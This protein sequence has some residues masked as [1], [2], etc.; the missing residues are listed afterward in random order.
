MELAR[1]SL[2]DR[3]G[4]RCRVSRD[5]EAVGN[6]SRRILFRW[7]GISG[8]VCFIVSSSFAI[9][10]V[11]LC[12]VYEITAFALGRVAPGAWILAP[13][14]RDSQYDGLS[15]KFV[16]LCSWCWRIFGGESRLTDLGVVLCRVEENKF[17]GR[18]FL[19]A[20]GFSE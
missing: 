18:S 19:A 4:A 13:S 15:A 14:G 1:P 6:F 2:W 17:S 3:G 11:G 5:S 7:E 9:R 20:V 10:G 12:F 16:P 8:R